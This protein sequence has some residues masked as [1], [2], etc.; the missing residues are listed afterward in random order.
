M[1]LPV[2]SKSNLTAI[3]TLEKELLKRYSGAGFIVE[4]ATH[5][6][7]KHNRIFLRVEVPRN[8]LKAIA[9]WLK[10]NQNVD[11]CSLITGI[12]WPSKAPEKEWE[13]VYHL[14]RTTV[15]NPPSDG[16]GYGVGLKVDL[17]SLPPEQIPIEIELRVF[18][19]S[20]NPSIETVSDLWAGANWNEKE[21]WDLV[22]IVFNDHINLH[23]V[24]LP[25]DTP[26]GYHPLQKQHKI[27]YHDFN[28]MYDDAQGFG[29][30]P[31]DKNLVK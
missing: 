11:H 16:S 27:R 13:V 28:E 17:N 10:F 25:S 15:R 2:S 1:S 24:L 6:G 21:T 31:V 14:V 22:G 20:D 26:I 8:H 30:K 23:R 9:K 4:R 3:E 12:H 29:R 18:L 19:P 7:G 5:K